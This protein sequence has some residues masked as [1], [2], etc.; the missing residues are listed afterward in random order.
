MIKVDL[1]LIDCQQ[2]FCNPPNS[3]YPGSLYVTGAESDMERLSKMIRRIYP[4][5]NDIHATLDTHHFVDIAHPIF[6]KDSS[7]AHPTPFTTI[8]VKDVENGVWTSSLP[9]LYKRSLEYVRTLDKNGRYPLCIWP[10]H[11]LI[12]SQGHG[13]Y[14]AVYDALLDWE[15]SF[16]MVDYVTKGSNPYTEHYSVIRADVVDP[17]DPCTQVN[18]RL[19]ETLEKADVIAVAGEAKDFCVFNTLRDLVSEFKDDS[20]VKKIVLLED[21]M[22]CVLPSKPESEEFYK[23]MVSKGMTV[24]TTVD[25][26]K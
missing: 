23:S 6:W 10:P 15:A 19:I 22:S 3:K 21:A 18:T 8:T 12:G 2:D 24:S 16:K 13:I 17:T 9:S 11:C 25:F 5:I 1:L 4:K 20:Y 7:G 26:L 14:P